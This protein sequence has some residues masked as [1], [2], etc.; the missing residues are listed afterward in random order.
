MLKQTEL[1]GP[2]YVANHINN[3]CRNIP[4]TQKGAIAKGLKDHCPCRLS[5]LCDG[6]FNGK[7]HMSNQYNTEAEK[8]LNENFPKELTKVF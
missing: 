5:W 1:N 4:M 6:V 8:L 3:Y 2:R 7:L